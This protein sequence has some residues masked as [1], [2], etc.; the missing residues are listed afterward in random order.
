MVEVPTVTRNPLHPLSTSSTTAR[1]LL[2]FMVQGRI[3]EA[4]A[5]IIHLDATPSG[6]SVPTSIVRP[7][8][9]ECPFCRNPPNLSWLATYVYLHTCSM[10]ITY[11]HNTRANIDGRLRRPTFVS[12]PTEVVNPAALYS[13]SCDKFQ[14][15]DYS[16]FSAA[17]RRV[18][19]DLLPS[20]RHSSESNRTW[21]TD[22]SSSH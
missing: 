13:I 21:T 11:N 10:P 1:H 8:C 22:I 16:S 4:N 17:G 6:L 12:S 20:Y 5:P 7:F 9:T 2:D 14:T 15:F 3:T 19:V 18:C